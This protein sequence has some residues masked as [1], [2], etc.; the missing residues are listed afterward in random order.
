MRVKK[1]I[2]FIG[3]SVCKLLPYN[4]SF[5]QIGQRRLRALFAR[6]FIQS[7]GK[8]VNI[9][10]NTR[11]SHRLSIGNYSGIGRN[12]RLY[13]PVTIGNDV[14]MG[15]ECWIYTQN[16]EYRYTDRPMRLQGPQPENPVIIGNDVWIG[17]RVT[18]LPGVHIGNGVVIGAGSVVTKDIPDNSVVAGNPAKIV[19]ERVQKQ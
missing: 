5:V 9:E 4:N 12:S 15:A 14:M 2:G 19:K 6:M 7:C 11:F 1:V 3:L 16:H 8:E 13:G 18:I 17:G 10:K